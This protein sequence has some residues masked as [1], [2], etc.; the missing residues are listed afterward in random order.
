VTDSGQALLISAKCQ[1]SS[2]DR[3]GSIT[4]KAIEGLQAVDMAAADWA[5]YLLRLL[6]IQPGTE[7][8]VGISPETLQGKTFEVLRQ[9]CLHRSQQHPL[10]LAVEDLQWID[11]TSQ[12]MRCCL[13]L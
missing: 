6:E 2:D 10:I 5:P 8:L 4:A 7:A 1:I 11:P 13:G 9:M 3:V 12:M